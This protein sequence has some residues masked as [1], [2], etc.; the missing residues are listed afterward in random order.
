MKP[1]LK[2][3]D[4]DIH[5][6]RETFWLLWAS[7][8]IPIIIPI[9]IGDTIAIYNEKEHLPVNI[10]DTMVGHKLGENTPTLNFPGHE[11]NDN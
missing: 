11:K 7:T 8:I 9:K 2:K 1:S 4:I 3:F 10:T 6:I 5:T